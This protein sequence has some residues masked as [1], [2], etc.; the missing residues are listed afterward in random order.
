MRMW[1]RAAR[2][3]ALATMAQEEGRERQGGCALVPTD[4]P[5]TG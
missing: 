4:A 1:W 3:D 2:F 5:G